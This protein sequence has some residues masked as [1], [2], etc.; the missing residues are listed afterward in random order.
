MSIFVCI[1]ANAYY[2]GKCEVPS[3][4]RIRLQNVFGRRQ[5]FLQELECTKFFQ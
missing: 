4:L 1:K 3:R 5:D 2:R